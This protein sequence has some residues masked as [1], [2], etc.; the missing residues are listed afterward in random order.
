MEYKEDRRRF[1]GSLARNFIGGSGLAALAGG[2]A[3]SITMACGKVYN[4]YEGFD[5]HPVDQVFRDHHGFRLLYTNENGFLVEKQ[6]LNELTSSTLHRD[7]QN[8]P[9]DVRKKFK[10][11]IGAIL[12]RQ[13]DVSLISI[14]KDLD[15]NER[16]F[17]N[18]LHYGKKNKTIFGVHDMTNNKSSYVEVHLPRNYNVSPGN[19][20]FGGKHSIKAEMHEVK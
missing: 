6:Y 11:S 14:I 1:I 20:V 12:A 4:E 8:I 16:G 3:F 13:D 17:A 18:V 15:N 2:A 7:I 10:V 9:E 19:E 5:S